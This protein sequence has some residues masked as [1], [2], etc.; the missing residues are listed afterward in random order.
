MSLNEESDSNAIY[1]VL[2][3]IGMIFIGAGA[4]LMINNPIMAGL[5][6]IGVVFMIISVANR[7]KWKRV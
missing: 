6:V 1:E 3:M 5:L 4:A 7:D 2:F